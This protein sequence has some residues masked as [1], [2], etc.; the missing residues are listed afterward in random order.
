MYDYI[1]TA[2]HGVAGPYAA[3]TATGAKAGDEVISVISNN[4]LPGSDM[5]GSFGSIIPADGWIF[6]NTTSDFSSNTF[7]VTLKRKVS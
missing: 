3:V 5:T 2:I 7:L 1:V 6:Q 4:A